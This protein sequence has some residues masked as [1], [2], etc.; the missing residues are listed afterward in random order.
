MRVTESAQHPLGH[1][2][3]SDDA[4]LLQAELEFY[5]AYE[6][7]LNPYSTVRKAIDHLRSEIDRLQI[8]PE[9]WQA[10]EI[11]TNIFLLGCAVLNSV[12]EYLRGPTLRLPS[13]V[14]ALRLGR[15]AK[16]LTQTTAGALRQRRRKQTRRWQ[17][18]W[19]TGLSDFLSVLIT[20]PTSDPV[21][22]AQSAHALGMVSQAPLPPELEAEHIGV[23]SPFRRLD[24]THFDVL[25]L[26]RRYAALFPHRSQQILLIG[27]RTSGSYFAPLLAA[28]LN[29]DGYQTVHWLTVQAQKGLGRR[30]RKELVRY[31]RRGFTALIVDDP[32]NTAGTISLAIDLARRAGFGRKRLKVLAPTHAAH[33]DWINSLPEGL[34]V[35]LEPEQWH[36]SRL[37]EPERVE[38]RL[39]EYFP[40]CA[41][42]RVVP[43]KR[44]DEFN[45]CLRILS[46]GSRG[47]RWK[48]V[49]ELQTETLLGRKETRYVL[50]KSVGW[51]W[52]GYHAFLTGHRLSGFV[53]AILGLRDGIL[54]SE[55]VP[56]LRLV[57][58]RDEDRER[59]IERSTSYVLARVR[60]LNLRTIPG[61]GRG[62][63]RDYNGIRLLTKA[64][65]KAYGRVLSDTLARLYLERRL[66]QQHCSRPTLID[67]KM[68][69]AEWI[70]SAQGLLK[71]DYEH[72]GLGK[73]ELNVIDPT[74]DLAEIILDLALTPEE[75]GRLIRQYV[76]ESGDDDIEARLFLNKLLA[77]L[78]AMDAAMQ[79]LFSKPH[80]RDL[81]QA[82]HQ[83][84]MR[85]WDFLTIQAARYCG[86]CCRPPAEPQWRAP[87]VALDIDGVLD[88]RLF[89]FP[90]TT[91][92][93]I[94]ALSLFHAHQL[95][96]ALNTA[97][98]VGEVK[99]Y[100]QAYCLAGGVAEHGSYLWDAVAQRERVLIS[101]EAMRQLEELRRRLVVLPGVFL[102]TRHQYSIRASTY[103]H[104]SR[105]GLL[106]S[107]LNSV[108]PFTVGEGAPGPLPTLMVQDLMTEL[109]LDRLAFHHTT[110]DTTIVAK[111]A[112]KGVG[113]SALRD[114]VL[115]PNDD[116][117]AVGDSEHDLPMFRVA[118]CSFAP[119]HIDCAHQAKL[120][121][122]YVARHSYQRGLRDIARLV[123]H[124]DRRTCARCVE[125]TEAQGYEREL[126]FELLRAADRNS[127]VSALRALSDPGALRIMLY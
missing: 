1:R 41:N 110:I 109:R 6:W 35:T 38:K 69:R 108:R 107:L 124:P 56:P 117:I 87:L 74:Y 98:S 71:T 101:P 59:R 11:A 119:A 24:L 52:L 4:R 36:L 89:G 5:Q 44:A 48:Q 68:Q 43:S 77:G 7:C 120:H 85:A 125:A 26:G 81:Q 66:S 80:A 127:A 34:V 83:R 50:A 3:I 115:Q 12:E 55:W 94:E 82:C 62:L 91:A 53:P 96:V 72:H 63:K 40:N 73:A 15:G 58:D 93:G 46:H 19:K 103:Q 21:A 25:S 100:C 10:A 95:C 126:F 104:K 30:E 16:W 47:S 88:R 86:R 70:A 8:V 116:T 106:N 45:A 28:C 54:Y 33:R 32:P 2:E 23:P 18:R 37:L 105:D 49:Y 67:G 51:G 31:A 57:D 60:S 17:E 121:G 79:Q 42:V 29:A 99:D 27:L 61:S 112:N 122:C 14:A 123:V 20:G 118:T 13:Q 102:D 111:E 75:E 78:W 64:L 84:Y 92:A 65:G 113:L 97:R 22:V 90:C 76:M 114:W 39:A 9:G